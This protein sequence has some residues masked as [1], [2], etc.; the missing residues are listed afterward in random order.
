M[1]HERYDY[2]LDNDPDST[3]CHLRMRSNG[4]LLHHQLYQVL[5]R[6]PLS[7]A[8]CPSKLPL[9][10][11]SVKRTHSQHQLKALLMPTTHLCSPMVN[12]R[13][14]QRRLSTATDFRL[15]EL[16]TLLAQ[17]MLHS[18][19]IPA[20]LFSSIHPFWVPLLSKFRSRLA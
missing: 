13:P 2:Y 9:L 18:L 17:P 14:L 20:N 4:R 15:L 3:I 7:F 11:L 6:P 16:C 12:P 19:L 8:L 5:F 1:L 10:L